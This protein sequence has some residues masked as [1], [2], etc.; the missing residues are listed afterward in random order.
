VHEEDHNGEGEQRES[1]G[2]SS[3][4]DA[5]EDHH[6]HRGCTDDASARGHE[7][8]ECG[9][10][11]EGDDDASPATESE[12]CGDEEG[13][14]GDHR[15]IRAADRGEVAEGG[16]L[17]GGVEVGGDGRLVADRETGEERASVAGGGGGGGGETVPD[18]LCPGE[19][20]RWVVERGGGRGG[21]EGE[22]G[23]FAWGVRG[24]GA[25][26]ADEG[27]ERWWGC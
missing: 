25:G 22:G 11:E 16:R 12:S 10:R 9:Q 24:E 2:G 1:L 15:A 4:G 27:A 19:P 18:L 23:G 8:D 13:D 26:D 7:D 20:P 21:G 5:D 17:H 3:P 14:G 6:G